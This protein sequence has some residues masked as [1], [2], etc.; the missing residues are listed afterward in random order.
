VNQSD[1]AFGASGSQSSSSFATVFTGAA[2]LTVTGAASLTGS[3]LTGSALADTFS[4]FSFFY[5]YSCSLIASIVLATLSAT[6]FLVDSALA[7]S[8][9]IFLDSYLASLT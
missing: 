3:A 9:F 6:S 5:S 4:A 8:S 1:F 7:A 2:L